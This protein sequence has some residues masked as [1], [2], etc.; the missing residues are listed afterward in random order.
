M[1]RFSLLSCSA[2]IFAISIL[3][4]SLGVTVANFV[5]QT[6]PEEKSLGLRLGEL[7]GQMPLLITLSPKI[8]DQ[9]CVDI[10]AV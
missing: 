10:H 7:A 4:S 8:S 2:G 1:F 9:I 5:L 3:I 6:T